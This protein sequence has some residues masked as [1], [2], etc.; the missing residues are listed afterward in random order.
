VTARRRTPAPPE[1]YG[2]VLAIAAFIAA[3]G[4]VGAWFITRWGWL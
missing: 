2:A 1:E 4:V 3:A